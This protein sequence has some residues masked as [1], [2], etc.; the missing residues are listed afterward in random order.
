MLQGRSGN[1]CCLHADTAGVHLW[2]LSQDRVEQLQL[3]AQGSVVAHGVWRGAIEHVHQHAAA[4]DVAQEL[5][6][7]P[8]PHVCPLE[9]P[10]R[11][12][13]DQRL[14]QQTTKRNVMQDSVVNAMPNLFPLEQP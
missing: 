11:R 8:M 2:L 6:A 13:P 10:C 14:L 4:L 12:E 9:Q 5:V 7:Q 3:V 1:T